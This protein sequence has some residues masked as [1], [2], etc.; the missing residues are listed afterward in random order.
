MMFYY[1]GF[2]KI[3]A[4][5]NRWDRLGRGLSELIGFDYMSIPLGFMAS[6]SES[7]AA[8]FIMIGLFIRPSTFLL[9]FTMLIAS[10]SNI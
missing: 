1:H 4:G 7:I 6:F 8:L 10:L 2:G 9:L 5:T 3:I